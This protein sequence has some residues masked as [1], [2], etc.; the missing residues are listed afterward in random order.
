M[1]KFIDDDKDKEDFKCK[2]TKNPIFII[3]IIFILVSY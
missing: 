2:L 1:L 3:I